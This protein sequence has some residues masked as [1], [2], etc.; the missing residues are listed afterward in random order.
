MKRILNLSSLVL[1]AIISLLNGCSGGGGA[2]TGGGYTATSGVAQKG[3][4]L[5]GSTVTAQELDASL[6]PTGKQYSY[7]V[8][9]DFGTFSPT[10]TFSSQYIGLNA[11]GYYFDEVANS[12]SAGPIILNGISDLST[13][14]VLNVNL[15]TTLAYQR[16]S[17][18]VTKSNMTFPAATSQAENEVLAALNIRNGNSYGNFGSL[19]ISKGRDGDKILAAI[20]SIF[21]YGN[22]SGTLSSLIANFQSDIADNGVIDTAA[23]NNAL[24]AA[25]KSLDP[26][27]VAS[28]LTQKYTSIGVSYTAT[29][30]SNWI[31]QDGDG[32]V[33]KCKFQ[34]PHATQ[35]STF[36]FP[37]SVVNQAVGSSI[38]LTAGQLSINGTPATGAVTVQTGDIVAVSPTSDVSNGV[39]TTYL[40]NGT[41]K[42]ARVS[43]I[44]DGWMAAG[45]LATARYGHTATLLNNGMVLVAGGFGG[46]VV[47]APVLLTS[48]ELYD[49]AT[50]TWSS[51][52]SLAHARCGH[53]ATLLNNGMVLVVGGS[54]S[55]NSFSLLASAE[56][57]NPATN[58]WSPAGSLATG[59]YMHTA[60]SLNNGMVL[61][62]GGVQVWSVPLAS[63]ELYNPAT[64]TWSVAGSLATARFSH[65]A[66]LL[67][68]GMVLVAG[69]SKSDQFGLASTELFNPATNTWS[70]AG[71]LATA[72]Y[73]HTATLLNNG[74]VLV[75]GGGGGPSPT[76]AR[77]ELYNP[78]T[79]TWSPVGSLATA[80]YVHTAT[81]LNNGM[82]L[83][84]C[85]LGNASNQLASAELHY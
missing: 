84:E 48:A 44:F 53:T 11:N 6:S 33:G 18:L 76:L 21:V 69:G 16:I 45:G 9:S 47:G 28:N 74:M 82:V 66:T 30:I 41:I 5:K 37:S 75:A 56:L 39:L 77:T 14:T 80:R 63:A 51:A 23:T 72:R 57:Y 49:P 20:S 81:L 78:A 19:E 25:A 64:N 12:I 35:S 32:V 31:D 4:L 79:N 1:I 60:T 13:D 10:S 29:D 65:T 54:G 58:T 7:Q 70:V 85:G 61:V 62:A 15:L 24:I 2:S 52:G 3:P 8:N 59:R 73:Y 27:L 36:T 22:S 67:N 26:A 55:N 34:V 50:N 40:M 83:V 43:F 42:M 46:P 68:N 17:N 71:S 38:S